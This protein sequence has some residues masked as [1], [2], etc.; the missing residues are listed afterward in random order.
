[1]VTESKEVG[2]KGSDAALLVARG[3]L[4]WR[5]LRSVTGKEEEIGW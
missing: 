1:M 4:K 5:W 2:V 3:R